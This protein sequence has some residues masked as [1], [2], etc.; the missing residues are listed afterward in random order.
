MTDFFDSWEVFSSKLM[1][2][3]NDLGD[4]YV[5]FALKKI[6]E[7]QMLHISFPNRFCDFDPIVKVL[8]MVRGELESV[9][10][11]KLDGIPDRPELIALMKK[12]LTVL[13]TRAYPADGI[14]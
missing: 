7:Q 10:F 14:D 8:D 9:I 5:F 11:E 12:S 2:L 1:E 4:P 6:S 3:R 13:E